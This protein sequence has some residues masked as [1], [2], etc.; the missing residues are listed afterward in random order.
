[1]AFSNFPLSALFIMCPYVNGNFR[2][3]KQDVFCKSKLKYQYFNR[4]ANYL[5][6]NRYTIFVFGLHF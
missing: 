2:S 4:K 3:S 6:Y 5:K 1:M